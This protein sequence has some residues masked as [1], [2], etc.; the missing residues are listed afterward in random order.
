MRPRMRRVTITRSSQKLIKEAFLS[1][2]QTYRGI[3]HTKVAFLFDKEGFQ[4]LTCFLSLTS[5]QN[6][7]VRKTWLTLTVSAVCRQMCP[8]ISL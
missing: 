7:S 3:A 1:I 5:A 6:Y 8:V 2:I 4:Q